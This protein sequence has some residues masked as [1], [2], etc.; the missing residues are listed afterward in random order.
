MKISILITT[1]ALLFVTI[2]FEASCQKEKEKALP[3][4]TVTD[5]DGNIYKTVTIGN[6]VWMAENLKVTR[7]N[8]GTAIPSV[9][10]S[11]SWHTLATPSFCYQHNELSNRNIYGALYNWFAVNTGKLAPKGWHIPSHD[12]WKTLLYLY[13]T[14]ATAAAKLRETGTAHWI[15]ADLNIDPYN[16]VTNETGFTALPGG[17]RNWGSA[18]FLSLEHSGYWWTSTQSDVIQACYSYVDYTGFYEYNL[19]SHKPTGFSIRCVKD[20]K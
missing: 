9:T 1:F 15:N 11:L 3:A 19:I 4:N 2:L 14:A 17:M 13:R 20:Y 6:Q 10:D 16:P 7:F 8:D 5:V 18:E 12:E